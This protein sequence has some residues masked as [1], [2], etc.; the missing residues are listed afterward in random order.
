MHGCVKKRDKISSLYYFLN[1]FLVK[2][3]ERY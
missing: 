3:T 1:V 2:Y